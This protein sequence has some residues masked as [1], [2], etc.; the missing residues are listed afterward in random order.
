MGAPND[1]SLGPI[2]ALDA[3]EWTPNGI[4]AFFD[5]QHYFSYDDTSTELSWPFGKPQNL[6]LNVAMGGGWGG[7]QGMDESMVSQQLIIDYVR[8]Y[9][10]Q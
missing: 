7:L 9:E 6:I 3:I 10:L 5:D 4:K 2:E 1:L 8:V